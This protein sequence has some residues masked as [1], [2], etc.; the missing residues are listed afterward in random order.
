[1]IGKILMMAENIN[2]IDINQKHKEVCLRA[3]N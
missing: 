1:M 2:V 3:K